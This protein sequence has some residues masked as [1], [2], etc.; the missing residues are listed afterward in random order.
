MSTLRNDRL[1]IR[2][3]MLQSLA[4][5]FGH[6]IRCIFAETGFDAVSSIGLTEHIGAR[7]VGA[8][9][10]FLR[11]WLER[12]RLK[13]AADAFEGEVLDGKA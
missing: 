10:T 1:F 8:Y 12:K 2:F 6:A 7:N 13:R 9:A 5:T 3:Q 4:G 11:T